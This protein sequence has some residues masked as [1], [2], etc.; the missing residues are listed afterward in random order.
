MGQLN[1]VTNCVLKKIGNLEAFSAPCLA[2]LQ[3]LVASDSNGLTGLKLHIYI[4]DSAPEQVAWITYQSTWY[5]FDSSGASLSSLGLP[6]NQ[7]LTKVIPLI[8]SLDSGQG[9]LLSLHSNALTT[10]NRKVLYK[11]DVLRVQQKIHRDILQDDPL[12]LSEMQGVWFHKVEF[13]N[14]LP[15]LQDAIIPDPI[16]LGLNASRWLCIF[17]LALWIYLLI[18]ARK[19]L[20][21]AIASVLLM[22][23]LLLISYLVL[24]D[25]KPL[26]NLHTI[27]KNSMEEDIS[28]L[29]ER[30]DDLAPQTYRNCANYILKEIRGLNTYFEPELTPEIQENLRTSTRIIRSEKEGL[31]PDVAEAV[32]KVF[33]LYCN[34]LL[35]WQSL[36]NYLSEGHSADLP[37]CQNLDKTLSELQSRAETQPSQVYALA[38]KYARYS[39]PLTLELTRFNLTLGFTASIVGQ[40]FNFSRDYAGTPQ[41]ATQV[42]PVWMAYFNQMC[43]VALPAG[44]SFSQCS[45]WQTLGEV[46]LLLG[47]DVS[48]L[49]NL[50]QFIQAPERSFR[51]FDSINAVDNH[52]GLWSVQSTPWG[53]GLVDVRYSRSLFIPEL[54]KQI[55]L[56]LPDIEFYL[57]PPAGQEPWPY[58]RMN[59][60]RFH[61]IAAHQR[62]TA[63]PVLI[64]SVENNRNYL[65]LARTF[66]SWRPYILVLRI[67]TTSLWQWSKLIAIGIPILMTLLIAL[68]LFLCLLISQRSSTPLQE[69]LHACERIKN[70]DLSQEVRVFSRDEI[71]IVVRLLNKVLNGLRQTVLMQGF[72]NSLVKNSNRSTHNT[73]QRVKA[74]IIFIGFRDPKGLFQSWDEDKLISFHNQ[75]LGLAQSTL[76]QNQWEIDKFTNHDCL[77]LKPLPVSNSEL[78]SFT[79]TLKTD[80]AQLIQKYPGIQGGIGLASGEVVVG[81]VGVQSR[82]DYTCIG[83]TVNLAARL[84]ALSQ[85][86]KICIMT[87]EELAHDFDIKNYQFIENMQ[88]KGKKI[89]VRVVKV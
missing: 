59:E 87:H 23:P 74:L 86:E 58:E 22:L 75:F 81:R 9:M 31:Y 43:Q 3:N 2:Q 7:W 48:G 19:R 18:K 76:L 72:L 38:A 79:Q 50:D 44:A 40:S 37:L 84:C 30:V 70:Q 77:G 82:M 71:S 61:E 57:F 85:G 54:V 47:L 39:H 17:T 36:N 41:S 60:G 21:Y 63:Q 15:D 51:G 55:N 20:V 78:H 46:R 14:Q 5:R 88:L 33:P 56:H 52:L 26:E 13:L 11:N 29:W 16:P 10:D 69:I 32:S 64:H 27:L 1:P 6:K 73:S 49:K 25:S 24:V 62:H 8:D 4:E 42:S 12:W 53:T 68:S 80:L 83:D 66:E 45:Y 65:Y 35:K 28:E 67:D 89:S 34:T